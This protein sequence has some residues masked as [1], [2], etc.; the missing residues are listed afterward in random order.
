MVVRGDAMGPMLHGMVFCVASKIVRSPE[1]L[2]AAAVSIMR[3]VMQG[4]A[5]QVAGRPLE[6][7]F[8]FQLLIKHRWQGGRY[9]G[10]D[11]QSGQ[12]LLLSYWGGV[13]GLVEDSASGLLLPPATSLAG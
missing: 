1:M 7:A 13:S 9:D 12:R 4:V 5:R 10:A 6:R 2:V 11:R 3:S 8:A